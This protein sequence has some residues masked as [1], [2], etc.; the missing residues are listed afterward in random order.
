MRSIDGRGNG[1]G[2]QAR[3][4][5]ALLAGTAISAFATLPAAA[6]DATW[7][8]ATSG[9]YRTAAN[10]NPATIPGII[11]TATFGAS[12]TT[13]L[14]FS[15]L[16]TTVGAWAFAG[17]APAYRFTIGGP[18]RLQFI[19]G[20][21]TGGVNATIFNDGTLFFNG[22]SS[23]G[24]ATIITRAGGVTRFNAG[25]SGNGVDSRFNTQAGGVFDISLITSLGFVTGSIEGAGNYIIGSKN[26]FTGNALDATVSGVISGID[27]SSWVIDRWLLA[28]TPQNAS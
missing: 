9:D 28:P 21:I 15:V 20:G 18:Q 4:M 19:N 16:N 26:L 23:S 5:R 14:T 10:W 3:L 13:D 2:N 12:G 25:G 1:S 24:G 27:L 17:T 7:L 8:G 22:N 6:Q 11:D